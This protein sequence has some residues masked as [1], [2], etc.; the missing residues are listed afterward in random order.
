MATIYVIH[1]PA[2]RAFVEST[3][4]KPL[5][6]L[7]FDRWLSPEV[8]ESGGKRSATGIESCPAVVVVVSAAARRSDTVCQQA[9]LALKAT[10]SVIPVQL[11]DTTP[12][13][14]AT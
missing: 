13:E 5:P 6:S 2:D 9:G 14:V 3:L 11:D 4:L 12:D 8:L 1:D 7:G 10:P